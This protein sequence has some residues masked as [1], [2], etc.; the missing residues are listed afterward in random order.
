MGRKI[1]KPKAP[2]RNPSVPKENKGGKSNGKE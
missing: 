1:V 2:T